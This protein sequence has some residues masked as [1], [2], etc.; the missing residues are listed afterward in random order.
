VSFSAGPN[1]ALANK[2]TNKNGNSFLFLRYSV[3]A[4]T[5]RT[6]G[7]A[8]GLQAFQQQD[9]V[10]MRLNKLLDPTRYGKPS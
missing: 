6:L 8:T 4:K 2:K 7:R 10:N 5:A 9:V 1:R 3:N